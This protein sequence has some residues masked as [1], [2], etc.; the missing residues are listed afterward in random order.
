M[1]DV[2]ARRPTVTDQGSSQATTLW[3]RE[4]RL[5]NLTY[6]ATIYVKLKQTS[7]QFTVDNSEEPIV[8]ERVDDIKLC[9][10]MNCLSYSL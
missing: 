2:R 1:S 10:V 8:S 9:S 4:A 7:T 3:P 6:A 5:R